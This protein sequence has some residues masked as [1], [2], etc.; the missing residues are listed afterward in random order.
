VACNEALSPAQIAANPQYQLFNVFSP[1]DGHVVPV[2]DLANTTV[3]AYGANNYLTTDPNQTQIYNGF[4]VGFNA[5]LPKGGRMFGGTTTERQ[6]NNSCST[7]IS[8]PNNLLY[9]NQAA[10]GDGTTIPWKTQVKL[11]VTYPLPFWGLIVNGSYQGLPGY[12]LANTTYAI[13]KGATR[14]TVC[15]GTSA[16]AG[17]VATAPTS[18]STLVAPTAVNS[19]SAILQYGGTDLTE[20][21]NQVDFGIAKRLKIGRVRIDPKVDMF[22]ALNSDDF[23]AVTSTAFSPIALTAGQPTNVVASPALT[24]G[25]ATYLQPSRFLQGRIFRLGANITW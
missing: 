14:Y 8:N 20:R 19:L 4:D 15:P 5:R 23:Y 1:I 12:T 17:C 7:G 13:T 16:A 6:L 18:T 2:Y 11:A 3:N 9:C 24:N 22:N 10:L 21:N 25:F